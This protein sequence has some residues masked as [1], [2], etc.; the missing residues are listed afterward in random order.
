MIFRKTTLLCCLVICSTSFTPEKSGVRIFFQND[1]GQDFKKLKV[2]I[3]GTEF[4]FENL[5]QGTETEMIKVP[6]SYQICY[7]QAIT[8]TDTLVCQPIDF[9]GA[10]LY[11][12]GT[13][14]MKLSLF[15]GEKKY[16]WIKSEIL[17][18]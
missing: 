16:M 12:N 9:V 2:D 5:R 6:E 15:P 4:F 8:D 18:R 17:G 10:K 14:L 3:R 1:T 7:A 13:L 11:R